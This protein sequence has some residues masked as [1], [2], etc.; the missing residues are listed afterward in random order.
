MFAFLP[1]VRAM[2]DKTGVL[3][4]PQVKDIERFHFS[5]STLY[6]VELNYSLDGQPLMK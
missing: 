3:L 5:M 6:I 1:V 4:Q 2:R